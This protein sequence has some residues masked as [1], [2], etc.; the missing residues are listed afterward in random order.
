MHGAT[1][2]LLRALKDRGLR[3]LFMTEDKN[4][5]GMIT[6][7][8]NKIEMVRILREVYLSRNRIVFYP[9]FVV[10]VSESREMTRRINVKKEFERQM[11]EFACIKE[12]KKMADGSL[13]PDFFYHGKTGGTND[14][15]AM[16]TLIAV[17]MEK[18]FREDPK[19]SGV[20]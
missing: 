18:R 5:P 10:A 4:R 1:P 17:L 13:R 8:A 11:R 20:Q 15:F 3:C 19:Y 7:H 12:Y 2:N 9:D 14:D 6:T 16:C